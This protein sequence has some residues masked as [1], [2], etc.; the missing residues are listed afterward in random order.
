MKHLNI[1]RWFRLTS[2]GN[3]QGLRVSHEM[4]AHF[5]RELRVIYQAAN[6]AGR[7]GAAALAVFLQKRDDLSLS[8]AWAEVKRLFNE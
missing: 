1:S 4:A 3:L 8:Q 2:A 7:P 6:K 5:P